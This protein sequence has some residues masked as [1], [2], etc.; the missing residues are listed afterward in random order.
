MADLRL[1]PEPAAEERDDAARQRE[2]EAG[3]LLLGRTTTA[4]LEGLEDPLAILG[5]DADPGVGDGTSTSAPDRDAATATVP[6][7]GVNLTALDTRLS[8]TCLN[9]SSSARTMPTSSLTSRVKA[10]PWVAARS[11]TSEST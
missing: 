11:R 10:M 9:F 5:G 3:A 7:S 2:S 4:L 6:P 8:T 1:Q